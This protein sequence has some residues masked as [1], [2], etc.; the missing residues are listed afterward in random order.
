MENMYSLNRPHVNAFN[1][2]D[3]MIYLNDNNKG[4]IKIT[5]K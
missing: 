1:R 2:S 4:I 5:M 3:N